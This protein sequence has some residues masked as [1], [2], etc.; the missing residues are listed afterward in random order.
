M[1]KKTEEVKTEEVKTEATA[2]AITQDEVKA[3]VYKLLIAKASDMLKGPDRVNDP[4]TMEAMATLY[5]AIK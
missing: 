1:A 2:P 3:T 4:H 5:N